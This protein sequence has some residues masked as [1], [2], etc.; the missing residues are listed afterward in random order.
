MTNALLS[1]KE[2]GAE[3]PRGASVLDFGCGLGR[4]SFAFAAVPEVGYVACV[5]HSIHHLRIADKEYKRRQQP[6]W[7]TVETVLSSPD[8]LAAV[9]GRRFDFVYSLIVLQHML[10]Q[11]Q[12]VYLEQFCD[13]LKP[14]GRALLQIPTLLPQPGNCDIEG[15]IQQGGLQMHFTSVEC[16]GPMFNER[17]C[18]VH[19]EDV[20]QAHVATEGDESRKSAYLHVRKPK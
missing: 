12:Q 4:L 5:D 18:H 9:A 13:V 10:P 19:V 14:G 6:G 17:G 2:G 7:G 1:L 20:G 11:L 15:S 16:F 3:L 8:L